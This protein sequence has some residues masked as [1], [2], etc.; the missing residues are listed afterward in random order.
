MRIMP[1]RFAPVWLWLDAEHNFPKTLELRRDLVARGVA[2]QLAE[3][4]RDDY[5]LRGAPTFLD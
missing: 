2:W 4:S 1:V 3:R 5:V